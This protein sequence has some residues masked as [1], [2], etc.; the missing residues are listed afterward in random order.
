MKRILVTGAHG[1]LGRHTAALFKEKGC[2]VVGLGHG[3]WGFQKPFDFGIDDWI[4]ADVD[5]EGLSHVLGKIDC[6][7]HC[8]GGS[9]VGQSVAHPLL[10]FQRTVNSTVHILEFIRQKHPEAM[11]IY[12]SSA[13]V[14]GNQP[15][16]PISEISKLA[17]VSPYGFY[18]KIAE[19][20]C[21]SYARNFGISAVI[22]RFFSIYGVGLQKQ[23]L[24][25]ACTKLCSGE[26]AAKFY[27]TGA[28]TRDWLHVQDAVDLIYL[29]SKSSAGFEIFNGGSGNRMTVKEILCMLSHEIGLSVEILMGNENKQGDP[30]HYWADITRLQKL[31]WAPQHMLKAGLREYVEWFRSYGPRL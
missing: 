22:I 11:I 8:A 4:E 14:Y 21:E 25:D 3:H 13:A 15:D 23:L 24:W 7:I 20:L 5:Q 31:G 1:F 30:R 9:S 17:P 16:V 10:E 2:S 12:P 6:V 19:D 27:G 18:K 28:E 29:L 26:K